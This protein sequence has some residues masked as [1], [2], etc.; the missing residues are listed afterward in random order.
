MQPSVLVSCNDLYLNP[1]C[2]VLVQF[3]FIYKRQHNSFPSLI[4][5]LQVCASHSLLFEEELIYKVQ[6]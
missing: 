3:C 1:V 6:I 5:Q 4:F 2:Q